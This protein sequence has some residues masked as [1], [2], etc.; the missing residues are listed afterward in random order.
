[1]T[2]TAVRESTR[3]PS[4][5]S[6]AGRSA[7]DVLAGTGTLV[8][9]ILRRERIKLSAWLLGITVLLLYFAKV[10]LPGIA[11]T[12]EGLEDLRRLMEGA[13]GA[14]FGPGYGREDITSERYIAGVYGLFFFVLTALMSMLLVSRHTRVEEQNG[15]AGR[16]CAGSSPSPPDLP[17]ETPPGPRPRSASTR[18]RG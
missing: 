17:S 7:G 12:A 1:M 15:R 10:V 3:A 9:F 14:V 13:V 18:G 11:G 4:G 8:R 16:S 2:A 5:R 6:P